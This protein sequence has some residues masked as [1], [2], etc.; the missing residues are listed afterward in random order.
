MK[1]WLGNHYCPED[2]SKLLCQVG[3]D[4]DAEASKFG[5]TPFL[6][7]SFHPVEVGVVGSMNEVQFGIPFYFMWNSPAEV[8]LTKVHHKPKW[9]L[10]V[11]TGLKL[12]ESSMTEETQEELKNLLCLSESAKKYALAE[13]WA[14]AAYRDDVWNGFVFSSAYFLYFF[15]TISV[16]NKLD[17]LNKIPRLVRGVVYSVIGSG[18]LI[19]VLALRQLRINEKNAEV[20]DR[21]K[22][23]GLEN[24]RG[25]IEYYETMLERGK[26]LRKVAPYGDYFFDETGA[27]TKSS[28]DDQNFNEAW[29]LEKLRLSLEELESGGKEEE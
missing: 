24:L 2:L 26:L 23:L 11:R 27:E 7:D 19:Q 5:V 21:M 13:H 6:C 1:D 18:L 17:A 22:S 28:S 16:N 29:K 14:K 3:K 8:D 15:V 9:R 4:L 20:M 12:D 25:G 10:F